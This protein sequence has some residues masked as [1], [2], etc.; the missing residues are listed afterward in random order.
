MPN[1]PTR[2]YSSAFSWILKAIAFCVLAAG[3]ICVCFS[4]MVLGLHALNQV[5]YGSLV[6]IWSVAFV[7]AYLRPTVKAHMDLIQ[8]KAITKEELAR[9]ISMVG[10]ICFTAMG[11]LALSFPVVR[12][13][14]TMPQAYVDN[15]HKCW[16]TFDPN[17]FEFSNIKYCGLL[18][19]PFGIYCGM[20]FRYYV[21]DEPAGAPEN[22]ID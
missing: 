7:I 16:N 1:A 21:L 22:F 14:Y 15:I 9:L 2:N 20:A 18:L 5:I 6:G 10:A 19:L 3:F 17:D 8:R 4:R 12:S 13:T 11:A